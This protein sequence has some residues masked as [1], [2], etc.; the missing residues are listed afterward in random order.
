MATPIDWLREAEEDLAAVRNHLQGSLWK[1]ACWQAQQAAEKAL[2]A[3]LLKLQGSIPKT[4]DL[5][6]LLARIQQLENPGRP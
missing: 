6:D 3:I 2:K 4:H 1:H 5:A